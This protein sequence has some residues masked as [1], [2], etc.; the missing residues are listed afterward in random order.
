M[1]LRTVISMFI[2]HNLALINE[3]KQEIQQMLYIPGLHRKVY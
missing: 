1:A 2:F 3:C